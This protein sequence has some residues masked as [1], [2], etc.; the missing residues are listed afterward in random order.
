MNIIEVATSQSHLIEIA[1]VRKI[2]FKNLPANR[3]F[4]DWNEEAAFEIFKLT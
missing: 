1:L 3:Y 4:F 2:D